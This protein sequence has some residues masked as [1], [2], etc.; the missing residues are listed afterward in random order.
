MVFNL[1]MECTPQELY[2]WGTPT[3]T[4]QRTLERQKKGST[5]ESRILSLLE[6]PKEATLEDLLLMH[7]NLETNP[8]KLETINQAIHN[9][10]EPLHV[11]GCE[12]LDDVEGYKVRG[13]MATSTLRTNYV[14]T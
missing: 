11:W 13:A 7:K 2:T 9:H 6:N 3:G 4:T 5:K 1:T 12:P 10:L 14:G 8:K